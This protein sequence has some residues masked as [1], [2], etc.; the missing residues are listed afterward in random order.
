M[1]NPIDSISSRGPRHQ[2]GWF[3]NHHMRKV[4]VFLG[5]EV[6]Q[7]L[8]SYREAMLQMLCAR[9]CKF[10]YDKASRLSSS[11]IR[12]GSAEH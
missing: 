6:K 8:G 9:I 7:P 10:R 12:Q 3:S 4:P 11:Q 5:V 1:I 2:L